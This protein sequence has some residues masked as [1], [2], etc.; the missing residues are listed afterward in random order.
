MKCLFVGVILLSVNHVA[1][2]GL[3]AVPGL[4]FNP[5]TV[6]IVWTAPTN[7][8]PESLW[9]YKTVK[10]QFSPSVVSN[11]MWLGGFT[12]RDAAKSPIA[13]EIRDKDTLYYTNKERTRNLGIYPSVGYIEYY[14]ESALADM[15]RAPENIPS[16]EEAFK[17]A[18]RHLRLIGVDVSQLARKPNTSELRIYRMKGSRSYF[19][20]KLGERV[21]KAVDKR[22]VY[23]VRWIDG[24]EFTGLYSGG[25]AAFEFADDGQIYQLKLNW[26]NFQPYRLV[27]F[28]SREQFVEQIKKGQAIVVDPIPNGVIKITV[29]NVSPFYQGLAEDSKQPFLFPFADVELELHTAQTNHYLR[30]TCPIAVTE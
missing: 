1:S 9:I 29:K 14:N 27:P 19:D 17:L 4:P 16:D 7:D 2:A 3:P 20:R 21:E 26:R 5:G 15:K 22:G 6:E 25:G 12:E 8:W 24:V 28:P 23:F 13:D 11:L 18:Q 30:A 10:Q